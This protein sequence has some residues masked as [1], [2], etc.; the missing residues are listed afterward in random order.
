MRMQ[1]EDLETRARDIQLLRVTKDLQQV[2][3]YWELEH[4]NLYWRLFI[5]TYWVFWIL[6]T[7]VTV[8][9]IHKYLGEVDQQAIQQKE[10]ATLEQTLQLYHKVIIV[11]YILIQV[12][13]FF[14]MC[15]QAHA[16]D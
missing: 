6:I 16:W 10:V 12:E 11:L 4:S 5:Y 9:L 2:H 8:T 3:R 15:W 13:S 14:P 1:I 7:Y